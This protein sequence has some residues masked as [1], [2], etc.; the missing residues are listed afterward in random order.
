[1]SAPGEGGPARSCEERLSRLVKREIAGPSAVLTPAAAELVRDLLSSYVYEAIARGGEAAA[2]R[3]TEDVRMCDMR[4]FVQD[5]LGIDA[6]GFAMDDLVD[7]AGVGSRAV[8]KATKRRKQTGGQKHQLRV[9]QKQQA[10]EAEAEAQ[11]LAQLQ[12]KHMA[13][14]GTGSAK[15]KVKRTG[16][17]S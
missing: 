13:S 11:A 8:L 16:T 12:R 7:D 2:A 4:G 5:E 15:K 3:G 9:K 6:V 10:L 14:L 17:T 1:M